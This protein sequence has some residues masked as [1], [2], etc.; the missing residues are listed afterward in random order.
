VKGCTPTHLYWLAFT[1]WKLSDTS[2]AYR[3][4]NLVLAIKPQHEQAWLLKARLLS[5]LWRADQAFLPSA[6]KFF[7]SRI[8]DHPHDMFARRE[9]YLLLSSMGHQAA[10]QSLVASTVPASDAT[11]QSLFHYA[12]ILEDE[13]RLED[14]I[15]YLQAAAEKSQD[16]NIVHKLAILLQ[17]AERYREAIDAYEL[18]ADEEPEH[19]L[20]EIANCYHWLGD[21][22]ES[23]RFCAKLAIRDPNN[24]QW[25]HNMS[26]AAIHLNR[27][28]IAI[29]HDLFFYLSLPPETDQEHWLQLKVQ[30]LTDAIHVEFG[31]DFAASILS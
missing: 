30:M 16:H 31:D 27:P 6:A 17:K 18:I 11:A 28:S 10:V 12:A 24:E 7:Q 23:L 21:H 2:E 26:Y 13:G 5:R 4:V 8:T 22:L 19:V 25:W 3:C 9:M 14:A 1:H 29:L 15:Q 20:P